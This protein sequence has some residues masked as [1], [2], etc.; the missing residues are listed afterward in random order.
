VPTFEQKAEALHWFPMFRTWFGLCGLC[1]LPWNDITPEDNK[2]TPEPAK[3]MKHVQW[4][5]EYFSA[6]TGRDAGPDDLIRMSEV[7]YNFQRIFNLRMGFGR[8]AQDSLPYRA[9]G[10]VTEIE[11][12]SRAEHYDRQ[13]TGTVKADIAGRTTAEKVQMLRRHREAQYETLKD[14]VYARRGWTPDGI[15]TLAT[16]TRL[17]IDFPEVV[18]LLKANGVTA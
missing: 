15:P 14:A 8:R 13:L 9:I 16:V 4:Y 11:Y 3:V 7:V 5:A 18:A 1:K 10:P 12:E 2:S 17:G 6:V